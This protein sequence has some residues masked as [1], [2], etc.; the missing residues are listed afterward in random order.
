MPALN[1][2]RRPVRGFPFDYETNIPVE[3]DLVKIP[4]L[5]RIRI[6]RITP[7]TNKVYLAEDVAL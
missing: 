6:S 3:N 2:I 7:F 4:V 5:K 1:K